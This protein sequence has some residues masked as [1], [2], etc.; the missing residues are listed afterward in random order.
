MLSE[1][2][3]FLSSNISF[4]N[5]RCGLKSLNIKILNDECLNTENIYRSKRKEKWLKSKK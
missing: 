2:S 4:V 5:K 3:I 1:P